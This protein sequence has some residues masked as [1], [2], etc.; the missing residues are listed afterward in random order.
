MGSFSVIFYSWF[1][2]VCVWGGEAFKFGINL[3]G[4]FTK[5]ILVFQFH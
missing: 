5:H 1:L 2:H 3:T 4:D